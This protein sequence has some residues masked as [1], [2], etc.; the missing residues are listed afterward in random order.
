MNKCT[1]WDDACITCPPG[2][3][4]ECLCVCVCVCKITIVSVQTTKIKMG[5]SSSSQV[6]TIFSFKLCKS[7]SDH[8]FL[9]RGNVV[10][11]GC[12]CSLLFICEGLLADGLF[13]RIQIGHPL[14]VWLYLQFIVCHLQRPNKCWDQ[15][16]KKKHLVTNSNKIFSWMSR[17]QRDAQSS[18][19][20]SSHTCRHKVDGWESWITTLA[21]PIRRP[22]QTTT[23]ATL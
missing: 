1:L 14:P 4:S 13:A 3:G 7:V 20:L 5:P 9:F 10:L 15:K 2:E 16:T 23:A 18:Q 22:A 17:L 21:P 8:S 11:G 6:A 12:I 19:C